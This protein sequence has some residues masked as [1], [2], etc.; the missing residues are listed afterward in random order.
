MAKLSEKLP[1]T[2]LSADWAINCLFGYL[3]IFSGFDSEIGVEMGF[4]NYL[5]NIHYFILEIVAFSIVLIKLE[6]KSYKP[7]AL[8]WV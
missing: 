8:E 4:P 7:F 5:W 6:M 1:S 3:E 2:L